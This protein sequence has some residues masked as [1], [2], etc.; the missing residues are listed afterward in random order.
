MSLV[1][2]GYFSSRTIF[3]FLLLLFALYFFSGA[4]PPIGN[5]HF[6]N[7]RGAVFL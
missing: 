6:Q 7:L 5:G 4:A 3:L 2:Q 1:Y